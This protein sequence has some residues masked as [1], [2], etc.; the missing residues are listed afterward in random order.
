MRSPN[1]LA[2][3]LALALVLAGF[4]VV[5]GGCSSSSADRAPK[6]KT[7]AVG[8]RDGRPNVVL[9][10]ADDQT[11]DQ[12]TRRIM[13]K[14]FKLL[15]DH[16]TT[17]SD[18]IA[19]TALC[20][21]SRASLITGQYA[22]NH[23]VFANG[24]DEGGYK[25][26]R[27]RGNVLPVWLQQAGYNTIHLG[28][29]MNGYW[30]VGD[31]P[32]AVAPGWDDWQTLINK[33]DAYYDYD[34]SNNGEVVHYGNKPKDY[35]TRVLERKAVRAIHDY[36]QVNAP[37]YL[38]FDERAP[39]VEHNKSGP[40]AGSIRYPEPAPRDKHRFQHAEL[41]GVPSFNEKDMRDKPQFLRGAPKI[42][43]KEERQ[44]RRHWRCSLASLVSVDRSVERVYDAVKK[45]GE[46]RRTVF[47]YVSDNGQFFGEHRVATGKVLPYEEALRQ[48]L[49][50][51]LPKRY[52]SGSATVHAVGAATGNID[53]APTILD[54]A[55]G[56][57][58]PAGGACRTMDGRSL[59][60]LLTD[61]GSWPKHRALLSEYRVFV[62][63]HY[64]TCKFAAIR[65]PTSLYAEHYSVTD[66]KK[67][68]CVD[69][70]PP[71]VERYDLKR[72]PFELRNLCHGG[73][74]SSC[75]SDSS[76]QRLESELRRLR[77]C[78]GVNGRDER[79]D[80]RPYCS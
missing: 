40:C 31:D 46:L 59:M 29:F 15:V 3:A 52:R 5:L 6:P 25:A 68:K 28:K 42:G 58:C 80:G 30:K 32:A 22:H 11:A 37:F 2:T 55:K 60:P 23:G 39:H 43:G 21:P 53:L 34:L 44:I 19:T 26:L 73:K 4:T 64:G 57:P 76:Q 36:S 74:L 49:V 77:N 18:Y 27:D 56:R 20:C 14:T 71:Q 69:A 10:Q 51:R 45:A 65:T 63:H 78:A 12:F 67:N 70:R 16:G 47:I 13:P 75:P 79:V 8:G 72:D 54:L 24:G 35:A 41:P 50:I 66:L 17:F 33:E 48:P 38:Q 61:K 7:T 62:P 1:R 9:I